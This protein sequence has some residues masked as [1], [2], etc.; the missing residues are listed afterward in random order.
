MNQTP[1]LKMRDMPEQTRPYERIYE[2]GPKQATDSELLS[3]LIQSGVAGASALDIAH[4]L[5]SEKYF[6]SLEELAAASLEQ[7]QEVPGIGRVKAVRIASAIE[8]GLRGKHKRKA[9]DRACDSP[10]KCGEILISE[11]GA[12][13]REA[14]AV[15]FL[16]RRNR[17]IRSKI[18]S[19]GSLSKTIIEPRDVFREGLKVNAA[20]MVLGHNHPSGSLEPSSSDLHSTS[21]F[22]HIGKLMGMPVLD[23][24]I[25]SRHSWK[26]L[27]QETDLFGEDQ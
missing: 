24:L 18:I 16:N 4:L 6:G 26:S 3:I 19:E 9:A 20:S 11:I 12:K 17:L 7:L 21:V 13:D 23:H 15:L 5:L 1:I 25:V 27:R 22:I 10:A 8:L 14:F 2:T